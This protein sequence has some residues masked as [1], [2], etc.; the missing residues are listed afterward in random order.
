MQ[1]EGTQILILE[2]IC[3]LMGDTGYL[4]NSEAN[5]VLIISLLGIIFSRVKDRYIPILVHVFGFK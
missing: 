1:C 4:G 5:Y 3:C 2:K